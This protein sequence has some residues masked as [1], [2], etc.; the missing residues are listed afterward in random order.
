MNKR[1]IIDDLKKQ[2]MFDYGQVLDR[3]EL[4][5]LF[6]IRPI[7]EDQAKG[8]T[9][10]ALKARIQKDALAELAVVD[11]LR[12][13]LLRDG[14]FFSRSGEQYRVALPSENAHMADNYMQSATRKL[15]RARTLLKATPQ[16]AL[17]ASGNV[18]SRLLVAEREVSKRI[19]Q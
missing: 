12:G 2:G 7:N 15:R 10:A 13:V 6:G 9:L 1:D 11:L 5:L 3:E 4:L 8:L 16:A 18:A 17:E 14:K 19:L